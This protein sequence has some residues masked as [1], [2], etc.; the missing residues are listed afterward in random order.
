MHPLNPPCDGHHETAASRSTD[1]PRHVKELRYIQTKKLTIPCKEESIGG[2]GALRQSNKG[3][4]DSC[5]TSRR[6]E[7]NIE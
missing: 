1:E 3:R 6:M 7:H 2:A 4:D 5:C